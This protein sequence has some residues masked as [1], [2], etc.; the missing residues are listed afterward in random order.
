[1][2]PSARSCLLHMCFNFLF[3]TVAVCCW[4]GLAGAELGI[5]RAPLV[6][7][8]ALSAAAAY[9]WSVAR[10][11]ADTDPLSRRSAIAVVACL[12]LAAI[13]FARPGEY[14]IDG[15]DG[16][17]Y[18]NLGRA[19]ARSGG[20]SFAEPILDRIDPALWPSLFARD[21]AWPHL[22]NV[23]PGGLQL[24]P[25]ANLV[26]PNFFHLFSVWIAG[27]EGIAG[28]QGGYFAN[29]ILGVAAVG[30]LWMLGAQLSGPATGTTAAGL[31]AVNF[32]EIWFARISTSE[33]LT[34]FL[35]LSGLYFTLC[36]A[37]RATPWLGACAGAAFGLAGLCRIDALVLVSPVVAVYLLFIARERPA[38]EW[39]PFV[40]S[41]SALTL[42]AIAHA[43]LWS[44]PYTQRVLWHV[45]GT[46][47]VKPASVA[48]PLAVVA[49]M[50]VFWMRGAPGRTLRL[51]A[52]AAGVGLAVRVAPHVVHGHPA[53]LLTIFGIATA[54]TGAAL[55]LAER[56]TA[57]SVLIVAMFAGSAAVYFDSVRDVVPMPMLLRRFVPVI[58]PL[59]LLLTAHARTRVAARVPRLGWAA[60]AAPAAL[61]VAFA[62]H[63]APIVTA[64]AMRGTD[65]QLASLAALCPAGAVILVDGSSPSHLGLSLRYTEGRDVL[66]VRA[67]SGPALL[68]VAAAA[69][70]AGRRVFLVAGTDG[71]RADGWLRQDDVQGFDLRAAG[72]VTFRHLDLEPT[73]DRLP[74]RMRLVSPVV[75]LYEMTPARPAPLPLLLDIGAHDFARRRDGFYDPERIEG[76]MARWS[77]GEAHLMLPRIDADPDLTGTLDVRLAAPRPPGAAAPLVTLD[78][79]GI[80][81]GAVGP[82]APQ[83]QT[84]S[85]RLAPEA[86]RA[87][88]SSG[89][90]L[91]LRVPAF[92]PRKAGQGT[93][94][95][96]LGVLV[97]WVRLD[98]R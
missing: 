76:A 11:P 83:F 82:I 54:A 89:R 43:L 25:D 69:G 23:F 37:R 18:L 10:A 16:S 44:G 78:L 59:A 74:S 31:L 49:A 21:P 86:W 63:S 33:M 53:M 8:A 56:P 81:L 4:A 32:A 45:F 28:R 96:A 13:L 71:L 92:V 65:A 95:R 22:L 55:M 15:G 62:V 30:A 5:Y 50:L 47:W 1:M 52:A 14:V 91:G 90:P 88:T 9:G 84:Y 7:G 39:L 26:R 2:R 61:G 38:R 98:G 73:A 36:H 67:G 60:W 46:G 48:A 19:V 97:D 29:V 12:V 64:A 51:L 79:A 40:V 57:E 70:A 3:V 80:P 66:S 77:A 93:D 72:A 58:L 42:H 87:L 20:L 41:F 34:Q 27:V 6:V 75:E 68:S 85:V 94:D 17:V 35:I 24:A